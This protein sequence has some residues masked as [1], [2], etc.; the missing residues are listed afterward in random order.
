MFGEPLTGFIRFETSK[1]CLGKDGRCV[2]KIASRPAQNL[3]TQ[4]LG[5]KK[6]PRLALTHSYRRS[7]RKEACLCDW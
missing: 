3:M 2:Y 5:A 6:G 1:L 7:N 4:Q